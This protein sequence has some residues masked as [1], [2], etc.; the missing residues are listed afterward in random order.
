MKQRLRQTKGTLKSAAHRPSP[1]T[2]LRHGSADDVEL[3]NESLPI[4]IWY[5]M[6]RPSAIFVTLIRLSYGKA[7]QGAQDS[8]SDA[9]C[10][11]STRR[12]AIFPRFSLRQF[13][14]AHSSSRSSHVAFRAKQGVA[15]V[16]VVTINPL[17]ES[18][19]SSSE[20]SSS[21]N[22]QESCRSAAFYVVEFI[23][24]YPRR[25]VFVI[26]LISERSSNVFAPHKTNHS[27]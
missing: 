9:L 8:A 10:E 14:T 7:S 11:S 5:Q 21:S 13:R 1:L 17:P 26:H 19:R 25:S 15:P 22:V 3:S 6:F 12:I 23:K 24:R 16:T 2:S 20:S 4:E 27:Q 18:F